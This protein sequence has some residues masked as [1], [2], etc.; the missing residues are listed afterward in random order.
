IEGV[1]DA[2]LENVVGEEKGN[3]ESQHELGRFGE[4]HLQRAAQPQRPE[5][6]TV[7]GG[8]GAVEKNAAKRRRPVLVDLDERGIHRLDRNEAQAVVDEVR[9]HV[10]QH[11]EPRGQPKPPDHA[12]HLRSCFKPR[13][14][15]LL[16]PNEALA[17]GRGGIRTHEGLAPL[18][19]FKTAAL[20]HSA[21]LPH[22]EITTFF[23]SRRRTD[24]KLLPNCYPFGFRRW[25]N[26]L[27][28]NPSTRVAASVCMPGSTWL[29]RSNVMPTLLCPRR[30][31]ATL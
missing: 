4:R 23:C 1:G 26:A 13:P 16:L 24:L 31:L 29:Y 15:A 6:Q 20:N 8:K 10:R 12:V 25:C 3:R 19:V 30:S 11:D 21:T 5:R 14:R 27:E 2:R 9:R 28:I 17:G 22:F 7:M 18:A